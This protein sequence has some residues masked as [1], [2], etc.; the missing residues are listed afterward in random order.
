VYDGIKILGD[1]ELKAAVTVTAH[2]FSRS[3]K[4][5]IE[6]AGGKVELLA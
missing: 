2:L 5:K 6:R 3:A 1:G 4:E